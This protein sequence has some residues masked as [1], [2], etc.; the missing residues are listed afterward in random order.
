M[1]I[2][3]LIACALALSVLGCDDDSNQANSSDMGMQI[4]YGEEFVQ[5]RGCPTCHQSSNKDAAILS[6][7]DTPVPKT[8][9]YAPN[10]TPDVETGLGGWADIE[11]VRAMRYGVDNEQMPL[12]ASMPHFDGT[13][14]TYP[15]AMT[16]LEA[17]AIVAYLRSLPAV[18]H[19]V[20]EST[21]AGTKPATGDMA[22]AMPPPAP[23]DMT[24]PH[25]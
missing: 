13:D 15:D 12:C 23:G 19:A 9:A 11:I 21:C 22:A 16:D 8:T 24:T 14:K 17:D 10:L 1:T 25:D 5:R 2:C 3:R 20:P 18:K 6:G 4:Q 7:S